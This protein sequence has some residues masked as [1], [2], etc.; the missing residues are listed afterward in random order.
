[1]KPTKANLMRLAERL[2]ASVEIEGTGEDQEVTV[3]APKGHHF[4]LHGIH[5]SCAGCDGLTAAERY[6]DA[7][8]AL[9]DEDCDRPI[10]VL[11]SPQ[12]P[13]DDWDDEHGCPWWDNQTQTL[14]PKLKS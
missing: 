6:G 12:T 11:C 7:L 5:E 13:C 10:F 14:N 3:I 4:A 8:S 9:I 1:M 2:G